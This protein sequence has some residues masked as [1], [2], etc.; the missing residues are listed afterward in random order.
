VAD[1][2]L[3]EPQPLRGRLRL[4]SLLTLLLV[5]CSS[6]DL[7]PPPDDAGGDGAASGDTAAD[8]GG[9]DDGGSDGG[10]GDSADPC[11]VEDAVVE[12][13]TGEVSFEPLEDG[14]EIVVINGPQGG[15]HILGSLR[16]W[17]TDQVLTVHYTITIVATG[18]VVSDQTNR[19]QMLEE[20]GD[21][22][23]VYP[24]M[25]GYLGF[26]YEGE[27]TDPDEFLDHESVMRMEVEDS[28]GRTASD[29]VIIIPV[30][31]EPTKGDD[32]KDPPKKDPPK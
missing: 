13:G 1:I 3:S 29:E 16:A 19:Y 11:L 6:E 9:E 15:Q 4:W 8:S 25:Y 32:T 2:L 14:D 18:E 31:G 30:L 10:T 24:G 22:A 20:E 12:V 27:D 17:H 21:C 26:V 28:L 5:G 23:W 7:P